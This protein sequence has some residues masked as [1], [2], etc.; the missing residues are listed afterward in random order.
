MCVCVSFSRPIISM[1]LL[2]WSS[3]RFVHLPWNRSALKQNFE[4]SCFQGA[5]GGRVAENQEQNPAEKTEP[6][7][8]L[9]RAEEKVCFMQRL[10]TLRLDDH[11]INSSKYILFAV[12]SFPY[13][14]AVPHHN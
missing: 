11:L 1:P 13:S 3:L 6:A 12:D 9:E 4:R 8:I 10:A 2:G 14:T 5:A 7:A